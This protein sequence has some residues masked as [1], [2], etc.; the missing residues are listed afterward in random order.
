MNYL[1]F[2]LRYLQREIS[3]SSD[4]FFDNM[5]FFS[6]FNRTFHKATII[7][8]QILL[9]G[10]LL[11]LEIIEFEE[12]NQI[13]QQQKMMFTPTPLRLGFPCQFLWDDGFHNLIVCRWKS[14]LCIQS[15]SD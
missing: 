2:P 7:S 9:G 15:L 11:L 1:N 13:C 5:N 8:L 6:Q 4:Y 14:Q 12:T 3:V 10:L